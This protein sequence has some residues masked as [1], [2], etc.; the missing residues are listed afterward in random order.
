M[1]VFKLIVFMFCLVK[2]TITWYQIHITCEHL[3]TLTDKTKECGYLCHLFLPF[4]DQF[5]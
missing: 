5:W 3:K 2:I 4:Q 1:I